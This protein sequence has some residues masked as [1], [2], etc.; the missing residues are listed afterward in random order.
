[1]IVIVDELN[2]ITHISKSMALFAHVKNPALVQGRPVLDLFRNMDVKLMMGD[3]LISEEP[4]ML[5]REIKIDGKTYH[6]S[7][8]SDKLGNNARRFIYLDDVTDINQARIDAEQAS[9][10]KSEF[11]ATMSHEIRTPMNAIIGMSDLMPTENLTSLQRGYFEDIKKMS[12]SLLTIINDI[13]DLSKIEAG[14]LEI[15]PIHYNVHALYDNIASM[16]EFIAQGN[17]LEFRRNFDKSMPEILYGDEIR[18]RQILTNIVNNAVKYTKEGYV[19]FGMVR[20]K[21]KSG[22]E[23]TPF[24]E[25]EYL[26]AEVSDSGIGIKEEDIPKLFD[27]FEQ[28]DREKNRGIVGTGLGLAITKKLIALMNGHIEVK[29]VYGSG[30]TFRVYLPLIEGDPSKVDRLDKG[31]FLMVKEGT[32]VLVVDD[33]PVN[34]MVAL[35]FL[36]KHGINAETAD[37]G[38]EAVK[39][40]KESV[41]SGHPYDLV[42]MDHMMP[43]MDGIEAAKHIRSLADA[44]TGLSP[45]TSMPIVALSA[46][47]VQGAEEIFLASGMDGFVSKPIDPAALNAALKNFLPEDKYTF[48][49]Q[50]DGDAITGKQ[51]SGEKLAYEELAKIKG[52]ELEAG[53][54]YTANSFATYTSTLKQFSAGMEK[55]LALI[56]DSLAAENW[57]PY[58]VQV[59]A[60]QG[61]CATIGM[62]ALS[63]WGKKLEAASKSE[64]KSVCFEET[65]AYCSALADFNAALRATSIFAA[66]DEKDRIEIG[67][68][69]MMAKLVKFADACEEGRSVQVRALVKEMEGLRLAG[70][71]IEFDAALAEVLCMARSLDYDE[72]VQKIH[73]MIVQLENGNYGK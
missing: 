64:N 54:H 26:V 11:L 69:D 5:I 63:E 21:R 61:I 19:F 6:F 12:K 33:V 23:R 70:A 43:D 30:S 46:N 57:N 68:T 51:D 39:K 3:I 49:E 32:R 14:K 50:E 35:G 22:S 4:A 13:L 31:P 71:Q 17:S 1:M 41:E 53:L 62:R 55:G 37:G 60:Y 15:V 73:A 59:H 38:I 44:D 65:D 56:R 16:C 58:T 48:A 42:F 28:F 9:M 29:S 24:D 7:I 18:V 40:I 72:A 25:T 67:A 20:G 66:D 8:V 10:A 45:Y 2:C 27:S 52:L 47:A 34:L 36:I